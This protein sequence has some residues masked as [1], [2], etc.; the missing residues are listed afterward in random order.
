MKNMFPNVSFDCFAVCWIECVSLAFFFFWF[1]TF[2]SRYVRLSLYLV[3]FV[4]PYLTIL[5]NFVKDFRVT[6]T[7]THYIY[8]YIYIYIIYIYMYIIYIIHIIYICSLYICYK[9]CV[10]YKC[11]TNNKNIM[12]YVR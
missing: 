11:I 4:Y 6:H 7:N 8:I 10:I 2:F 12:N 5:N 9:L 1:G 3:H